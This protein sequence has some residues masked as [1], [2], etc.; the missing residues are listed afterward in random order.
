MA[1]STFLV[2]EIRAVVHSRW[3]DCQPG[4]LT[5]QH[6]RPNRLRTT[7]NEPFMRKQHKSPKKLDGR[8]ILNSYEQNFLR[9]YIHISELLVFLREAQPV[10]RSYGA[11]VLNSLT[12]VNFFLT[13]IV[14]PSRGMR[15]AV[16][17][18]PPPYLRERSSEM[19]P[20]L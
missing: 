6:K 11:Q 8:P 5:C 13:L 15:V 4:D 18:W 20:V 7:T 17:M 3:R 12:R 10:C 9:F 1:Q 16:V 14:C 2:T 19:V